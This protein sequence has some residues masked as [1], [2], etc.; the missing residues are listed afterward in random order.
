[1]I[2]R[3]SRDGC[4]NYYTTTRKYLEGRVRDRVRAIKRG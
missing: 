3:N 1:M 2:R 4:A